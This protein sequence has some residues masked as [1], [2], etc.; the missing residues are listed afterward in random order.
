MTFDELYTAHADRV[1]AFLQFKLRD[2]HL[3]EDIFQDTFLTAYQEWSQDRKP[4]HPRAWLLTIAHRRM[5]DRLRKAPVRDVP[6]PPVETMGHRDDRDP[7]DTILLY[8]LLD[9]L[10][11]LS[12]TILYAL[13]VEGL[14]IRETAQLTGM[15]E[16]T[17]K[18]RSYSAK[19]KL[20]RWM[21]EA[22]LDE[23]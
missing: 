10:D 22:V 17:V 2:I 3:A 8:D 9:R 12:R 4:K 16:G 23:R 11:E 14:T 21:K 13:Y 18:S 19:S 6:L 15:P 5:V 7:T 20:S 1:Y